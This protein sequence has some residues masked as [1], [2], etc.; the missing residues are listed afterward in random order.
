ANPIA[1]IMSIKMM[2][3]WMGYPKAAAEVEEAVIG[4]IKDGVKTVDLGGSGKCSEV[5][6]HIAKL[7]S[8]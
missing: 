5:G 3:D 4:S 2:L 8:I 6:N 7:I 1:T